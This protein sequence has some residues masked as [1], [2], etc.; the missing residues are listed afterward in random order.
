MSGRC[1]ILPKTKE[2]FE[3]PKNPYQNPVEEAGKAEV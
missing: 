3:N 2:I 1:C